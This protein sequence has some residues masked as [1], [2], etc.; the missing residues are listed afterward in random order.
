MHYLEFL[1]GQLNAVPFI[2]A[3]IVIFGILLQLVGLVGLMVFK[4]RTLPQLRSDQPLPGVSII[5]PC[6][7][8][9]DSEELNFDAFFNQSYAGKIQLLFVV[10]HDTD[11]IVPVIRSYLARYP[12]Y[13]AKLI[14]STTRKAYWLK[15]DAMYDAHKFVK[16]ELIIW[17]DSDAVVGPDYVAQMAACLQEPGISMVTTPQYDIRVN[18][19]PT[20]LKVLGNNCDVAVYAMIFNL[21]ARKINVGWGHSLGFNR[22]DFQTI[23]NK[24]WET[25]SSSFGDDILLPTLF[26]QNGKKVVFRNV[27]C[28]VQ[29]ASKSLRQMV[30]QQERFALCQK[31][32]VGKAAII[33]G[34]FL[35]VQIPATL[36]FLMAPTN[37]VALTLFFSVISLRIAISFIFEALIIG[38]VRMSLRYFWTIPIWD[39]MHLYFGVFA[40]THNEVKYHGK[41][42]RFSDRFL[43]EELN[44]KP[45]S[46][47]LRT[48]WAPP[49]T[50]PKSYRTP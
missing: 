8:N 9:L 24:I 6:F 2:L 38:S 44:K 26:N 22:A 48:E 5:K 34:F 31:A 35:Y 33:L 39:L 3:I 19:I 4:F 20:A 41:V 12:E 36:L 30:S 15:V 40:L 11:P 42:F 25:L 13:D 10:S 45:N 1:S 18:N 46:E 28:P 14:V 16:H 32:F 47:G 43:L 7:S 17:S 29:Y 37:P 23:E 49:E 27:Y 50:N 21:F